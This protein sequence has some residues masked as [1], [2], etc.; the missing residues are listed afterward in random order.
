MTTPVFR[1]WAKS[2]RGQTAILFSLILLPF[3]ALIGLSIDA[4]RQIAMKAHAQVAVDSAALAAARVY[5]DSFVHTEVRSAATE[6]FSAN[7]ETGFADATCTLESTQ[8]DDATLTITIDAKCSLP[9]LFGI[10]LVGK[11]EAEVLGT[12]TATAV[13]RVADVA[14]MFDLSGSMNAAELADLKAA[15]KRAAEIIIG[16]QSGVTGRVS[17]IGFAGG[18]NAG[19]FGNLAAGRASLDDP[20]LDGSDRVCVTE[21]MGTN[22]FTDADPTTDPVGAPT[23]IFQ[24][25][26]SPEVDRPSAPFCPYSSIHPL[27]EDLNAVKAQIDALERHSSGFGWGTAGHLGI[28]WS[29][30]T[31]SPNWN[32]V[33]T[34]TAYG[35]AAKFEAGPYGDPN[36]P[37]VAILMSDGIFTHGFNL[38]FH[39]RDQ[40]IETS[41]VTD[42]AYELCEGMRDA[43]ITIYAIIYG[44]TIALNAMFET[45]AGDPDN[46]FSATDSADLVNVYQNL[47]SRYLGVSLTD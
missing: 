30:Y 9:T 20:E 47:A 4:T 10:D 23:T 15:G 24:T 40:L 6:T 35:G 16:S 33:W 5:K 29:W 3:L 7:I 44:P 46:V 19:D 2:E 14:L 12:S 13:H 31:L 37:K 18:L 42:A 25:I 11:S 21:R 8:I 28:A 41:N 39:D 45:C 27:D 36:Q 34:D 38:G 1:H 43:G 17:V 22:A 26:A 32:S